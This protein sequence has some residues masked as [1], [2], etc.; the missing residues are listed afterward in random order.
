[1]PRALIES[2]TAAETSKPFRVQATESVSVKAWG[3]AGAEEVKIQIDRGD[4]TFQDILDNGTLTATAYQASINSEGLY[5][6]VKPITVGV[7][8]A[9]AG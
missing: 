2:K 8:G 1:M 4:G 9:S 6:L 3:L 5:V 7:A